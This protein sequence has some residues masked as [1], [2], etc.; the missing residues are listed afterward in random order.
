MGGGR[1]V[2]VA[3]VT[4]A[5]CAS[6][7]PADLHASGALTSALPIEARLQIDEVREPTGGRT[8]S[9]SLRVAHSPSQIMEGMRLVSCSGR[10]EVIDGVGRRTYP[11][12]PRSSARLPGPF[13]LAWLGT[14]HDGADK[15]PAYYDYVFEPVVIEGVAASAVDYELSGVIELEGKRA[16][17]SGRGRA[18]PGVWLGSYPPSGKGAATRF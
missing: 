17:V 18:L 12:V 8:L 3:L 1:A 6:T 15:Q 7:Q 2:A 9:L 10:V 4:A 16:P 11:I 14:R 5:A 13:L